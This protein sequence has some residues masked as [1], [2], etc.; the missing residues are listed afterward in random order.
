MNFHHTLSISRDLRLLKQAALSH[1]QVV[2]LENTQLKMY[3]LKWR[4]QNASCVDWTMGKKIHLKISPT[5]RH[6]LQAHILIP[7]ASWHWPLFSIGKQILHAEDPSLS[8]QHFKG[9]DLKTNRPGSAQPHQTANIRLHGLA[10]QK[11]VSHIL[12][13]ATL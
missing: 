13:K 8:S 6:W 4:K 11:E 5:S 3:M 7:K 9:K 10:M 12:Y 2:T 1:I